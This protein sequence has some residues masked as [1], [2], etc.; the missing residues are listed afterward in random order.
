MTLLKMKYQSL[1]LRAFGSDRRWVNIASS[2][3][4]KNAAA[5]KARLQENLNGDT[6]LKI[7]R[8]NN[9]GFYV[10]LRGMTKGT[11][12]IA[13]TNDSDVA[14]RVYHRVRLLVSADLARESR[15]DLAAASYEL[16]YAALIAKE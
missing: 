8:S 11:L 5:H 3:S 7:T 6:I 9:H 14:H 16:E 12:C 15:D 13:V 1:F 4:A 2:R 10:V